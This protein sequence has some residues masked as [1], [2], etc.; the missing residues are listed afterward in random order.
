MCEL[1]AFSGEHPASLR[2]SM[3]EFAAHS[4]GAR[5]AE[6]WGVAHYIDGD[7][8]LVKEPGV[9]RD[10]ACLNFIEQHPI[11][12]ALVLSHLRHATQG[13]A[14]VRNCQ[15]F[16]REL[17]GAMHVFAHNGN[18]DRGSLACLTSPDG[19]RPVGETDSELA[20]CVLLERLR[21]LWR[22]AAGVPSVERRREIVAAFAQQLRAFGPAN[23][24]YC[25][26]DALFANGY[27]RT[28]ADGD[29]RPPGPH[30]LCRNCGGEAP[31]FYAKGL[32]IGSSKDRGAQALVASWPLT[33]DKIWRPL[34]SGELLV[35]RA[36][37]A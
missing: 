5:N 10:S 20:F 7:V 33:A 26:G 18:L 34:V 28:Q 17:G 24:I 32:R 12:S 25:D 37:R 29:V 11:R 6:G 14:A 8:R 21:P 9:A 36:G 2:Y 27:M 30:V 23:V 22:G 16:V 4:G 13:D 15:P 1:F 19:F 35:L 3:R 31:S